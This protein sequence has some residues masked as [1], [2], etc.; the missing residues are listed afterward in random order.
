MK[1]L[2]VSHMYPSP[3]A[4][5]YGIFVHDQVKALIDRGCRV[6]VVSPV[7]WAPFP[8]DRMSSKW[9][10][11]CRDSRPVR[12][13]R[14]RRVLSPGTRC[15]R[16]RSSFT[17]R[18]SMMH[19]TIKS[20]V[21]RIHR[22]F[23]FDLIH[24]HVALPDGDAAVKLGRDLRKPVVVTV[25]GADLYQTVHRSERCRQKLIEVF[26]R[27]SKTV[28]VSNRLKQIA[29]D[30]I[31]RTIDC[32]VIGN[33]ISIEALG[34]DERRRS[35]ASTEP[36]TIFSAS[37]LVPRKAIRYNIMALARVVAKHEHIRYII[38]GD[39]PERDD[40]RRLADE[41]GVESTWNSSGCCRTSRP[42]PPWPPR[43]FLAPELGRGVRRRLRRGDGAGHARHR[44][45]G[46]GIEDVVTHG[47]T[48]LLVEPRN[49][50]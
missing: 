30:K 50:G 5:V 4:E 15:S 29:A 26:D 36:L 8:I 14:R 20:T 6:K 39:G 33:G 11:V 21:E 38:A 1:V 32:T 13:G 48:G 25:H 23:P 9:E 42:W 31:R 27:V 22:E 46:E 45:P 7:P 40:L 10:R 49:G 34:G 19:R 28:F 43:T 37:Y 16:G 2:I 41:L 47:E 3:T 18:G 35:R 12:L 24:A 17:P 44:L